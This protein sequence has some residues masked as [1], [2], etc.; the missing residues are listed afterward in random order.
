[1]NDDGYVE[2]YDKAAQLRAIDLVDLEATYTDLKPEWDLVSRA[3]EPLPKQAPRRR[4]M[5]RR[6]QRGRKA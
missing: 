5:H 2:D 4:H 6:L 3:A 1:M